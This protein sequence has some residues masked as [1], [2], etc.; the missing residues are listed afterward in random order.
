MNKPI[1]KSFLTLIL[2]LGA[3]AV[4]GC[5]QE[6]KITS[7]Q[8][9][10]G[11]VTSEETELIST[12]MVDSPNFVPIPLSDVKLDIY[13]NGIHMGKGSAVGDTTISGK[14]E[15]KISSRIENER[16]RDWW[17]THIR[18][19]E[20][21]E[22][23]I[24]GD[25]VFGVMGYGLEVPVENNVSFNTSV[26]SKMSSKEVRMGFIGFEALAMRNMEF[27]W[28]TEEEDGD[29]AIIV[30]MDVK[31]NLPVEIPLKSID[32]QMEMNGVKIAQGASS[33]HLAIPGSGQREITMEMSMDETKIP[34][35]WVTHIQKSEKTEA[36]IDMQLTLEM[37]GEEQIVEL[38]DME[39]EFSTNIARS[40]S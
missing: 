7:T 38:S 18:N 28:D 24:R 27:K 12:V 1:L 16:L 40:M 13:M 33:G 21:T 26:L 39:F 14:D 10:W 31:N 9:K 15:L 2:L 5:L 25:L 29:T 6:P 30:T 3:L 35:W 23:K 36:A 19:G 22:V 37:D 4:S 17:P 8:H 20:E 32:Y 11:D 34:Q